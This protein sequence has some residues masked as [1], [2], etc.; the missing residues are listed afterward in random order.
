MNMAFFVRHFTERGTEVA[1]YDYAHFNEKILGNKSVIVCFT[2][3]AQRRMGFPEDRTSYKKFQDRFEIVEIDSMA[4]IR[5]VIQRQVLSFFYTLTHG[6]HDIYEFND[7]KIWGG[8]Q[9]IKHAVFCTTCPES[10]HYISISNFLNIK[11]GTKLPVVPHMVSSPPHDL[12]TIRPKLGIPEEAIV[13]GRYGGFNQ[14]DIPFVHKA[15]AEHL[16]SA[17]DVYFLFMNTRPFYEHPRLI[18]LP[19]TADIKEKANFIHSCDAM[20]HA[21]T[22]GETFGLSIAEFSVQGKPIITNR[23]L[24]D[25]EHVLIL[26][27]RG[28]YYES[29]EELLDVFQNIKSTL[30]RTNDWNAYSDYSPEIVM[31]KFAHAVGL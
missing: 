30:A 8:C 20:I 24:G 19:G 15:I 29:K 14:F 10:D 22:E 21:R 1:T 23:I 2:Q 16:D 7:K 4:D 9:T 25:L 6:G 18:H 5:T 12:G 11:S 13:F 28:V 31:A 26:G 3:A 27:D 17:D